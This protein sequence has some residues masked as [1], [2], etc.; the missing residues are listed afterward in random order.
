MTT[1]IGIIG[2]FLAFLLV[3]FGTYKGYNLAYL[4]IIGC[5]IIIVSNGL[6]L[7]DTFSGTVME[8]VASQVPTLLPLYVLGAI[9]GKLF[10]DSGA[11]FSL[12]SAMLNLFGRKAGPEGRRLIGGIIIVA[13]DAIMNFVGIDPFASLFTMIA[14]ATGMMYATDIPRRFMPVYLVLGSAVGS[15]LPGSIAT[16]N[17]LLQNILGVGSMSGFIPGLVSTAI[18]LIASFAYI[19]HMIKKDVARGAHFEYGPLEPAN[20][21]GDHMPHPLLALAS[22]AVIIVSFNVLSLPAWASMGV[23]VVAALVLLAR[24]IPVPEGGNHM[25]A[26][27]NSLNDGTTIAGIPAITLM[28]YCLGYA[29]EAT[30]SFQVIVNFFTGMPGPALFSLAI[31]GTLLL[32]VAASASGLILSASIAMKTYIPVLGLTPEACFRVLAGTNVVLDSLPF[33]GAIV[34]MMAITGIKYKD[35]YPPIAMTTVV[36]TFVGLMVST[37]LMVL[38]PGLA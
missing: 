20:L 1:A 10:I 6:P 16:P 12:S 27:K 5:V 14:I 35:G 13:M 28:S 32:G 31:M 17:I 9:F 29:I 3:I 24:Y 22:L 15:M 25:T 37:G 19:Q 8:G 23:G 2:I 4:V 7:L 36:F 11:A 38:F 33:A 21:D 34:A 18:V 26:I 30:D